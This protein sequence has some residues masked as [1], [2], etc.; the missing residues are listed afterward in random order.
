[1]KKAKVGIVLA[2][3]N[4]KDYIKEQIESILN[5]TY[6][7][8]NLYIYDDGSTDGSIELV[9]SYVKQ[10]K[11][12]IQLIINEEN[13]GVK[14]N[15]LEGMVCCDHSY[16]MFCDQD[17]IWYT[18]KIELTL[19]R[20]YE[21]EKREGKGVPRVVFTDAKVVSQSK[22]ELSSSFHKSNHLNTKKLDLP[23]LLMENKMMGCTSMVNRALVNKMAFLPEYCKMH[24]WWIILIG[25]AFGA[26][27][28]IDK[29]TM[30]YRQHTGN[31]IGDQKFIS[32]V[33]RRITS[34]KQQKKALEETFLQAKEFY[35]IYRYQLPSE[36]RLLLKT[37]YEIPTTNW[38][39]RRL[40]LLQFHFFKS[41]LLR[42]IGVF[43]LI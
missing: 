16:V 26:V 33:R 39:E 38:L 15:F 5:N 13:K 32:Y 17:D 24:D 25:C 27:E 40:I 10:Y 12:K 23:H 43:I 22:K 41:G 37:F 8:W 6:Q 18:D 28:Y 1:M 2:S 19:R 34:M 42:N 7:N 29:P 35:H 20:M 30:L 31:V 9:K 21:G 14:R 4:G 11:G 3:F 36:K